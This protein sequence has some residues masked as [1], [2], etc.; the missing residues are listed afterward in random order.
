V[1][2]RWREVDVVNLAVLNVLHALRP[3]RA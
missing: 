3:L 2:L 1:Q